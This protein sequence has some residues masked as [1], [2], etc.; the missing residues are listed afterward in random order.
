MIEKRETS[1]LDLCLRLNDFWLIPRVDLSS[2]GRGVHDIYKIPATQI[3][4]IIEAEE[5]SL[6]SF[7]GSICSCQ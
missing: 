2:I 6:F 1:Y 5:C 7:K 3:S 4:K